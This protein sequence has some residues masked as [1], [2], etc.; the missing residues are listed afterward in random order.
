MQ[1]IQRIELVKTWMDGWMDASVLHATDPGMDGWMDD[2]LLLQACVSWSEM[3]VT[4]IW[5][6]IW[7][8]Y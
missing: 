5:C 8:P 4:L 2:T 6:W 7:A 1:K 3:D